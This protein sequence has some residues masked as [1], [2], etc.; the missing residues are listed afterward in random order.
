MAVD[1]IT[2]GIATGTIRLLI[3]FFIFWVY[4]RS[5]SRLALSFGIFFVLLSAQS[6][7]RIYGALHGGEIFYFLHRFLLLFGTVVILEGLSEIGISWIKKYNMPFIIG[8]LAFIASYYNAFFLGG[9]SGEKSAFFIILLINL[10]SIVGLP[11]AGYYFYLCGKNLPLFG[12][13]MMVFGFFMQ[14]LVFVIA[15]W[16]NAVGLV[17]ITF[18]LGLI[19]TGMIGIG[20]LLCV[21]PKGTEKYL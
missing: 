10:I 12:R 2:A 20:W 16:L 11:L 15:P 3:G 9:L 5:R 1:Q 13:N 6:F 14:G 18:Y 21:E 19:F 4:Y 7:F 8:A 17:G